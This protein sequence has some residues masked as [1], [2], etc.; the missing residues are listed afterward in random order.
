[1]RPGIMP[2]SFRKRLGERREKSSRCALNSAVS[3]SAITLF[4]I[5]LTLP[6]TA[7]FAWIL[8]AGSSATFRLPP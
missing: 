3:V 5:I 7:C 8:A 2:G 1:M 6:E 4:R